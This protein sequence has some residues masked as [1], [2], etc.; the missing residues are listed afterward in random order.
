M[1]ASLVASTSR[2]VAEYCVSAKCSTLLQY[3]TT[4]STGTS[5]SS[6]LV[7]QFGKG[8]LSSNSFDSRQVRYF[9]SFFVHFIEFLVCSRSF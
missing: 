5:V 3:A 9:V 2:S 8:R 6:H 4:L 7:A 1:R